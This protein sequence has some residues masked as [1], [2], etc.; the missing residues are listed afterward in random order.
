[1]ADQLIIRGAREHN[2]KDVSLDLPRDSLIVFTGLSGSGKSSLG[3]RHD[4]RRGPAPLRRV[5]VG[6]RPPVPRPDGQAR[7]R[8]HRGPVAGGL[9]R[10][11]V[12]VEEPALHRRH[13]HRGLR[14]PAAAVRPR[15]S[16]ALPRPAARPSS[17]RR[18]SRSS[19]GCSRSRRAA[20]PGARAGHPRP[21]GRVR[22]AVPAAADPG[23]LPGAGQRR[24]PHPRR[25]AQARQAEEAHHRGGGRPARGQGVVQAPAHRLGRDRPQ[26]RRRAGPLRLR[27][28][29]GQGRRARAASSARRWRAPTT[30]PSTPTSS[31]PAR[32]PSTRRSAPAP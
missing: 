23:L 26:P 14:L 29:P 28:P 8:L 3:V 16:P 24:D 12:H 22:R 1:M 5:A 20:V 31:S 11:E 18:R 32:S 7:R 2:L 21:Q 4:L 30:T 25:P 19:T 9:D 27:R 15:R 6:V 17:G 13:H 10:P